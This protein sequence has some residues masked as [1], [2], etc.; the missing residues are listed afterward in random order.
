MLLSNIRSTASE[1]SIIHQQSSTNSYSIIRARFPSWTKRKIRHWK[2]HW[3]FI[4]LHWKTNVLEIW[5]QPTMVCWGESWRH[6]TN[7][8]TPRCLRIMNEA[9]DIPGSSGGDI[10]ALGWAGERLKCRNG[11]GVEGWDALLKSGEKKIVFY[12][13]Y[14]N[15]ER[16]SN[17]VLNYLQLFKVQFCLSWDPW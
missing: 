4:W 17:C 3:K 9:G 13:V 16:D 1:S 15:I 14:F 6:T 11:I 12:T 2:K 5:P 8:P 7:V 10:G